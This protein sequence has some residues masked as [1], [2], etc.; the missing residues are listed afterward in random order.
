MAKLSI[1]P[2]RP[3]VRLLPAMIA[4]MLTLVITSCSSGVKEDL[5]ALYN[6]V[7]SEAAVVV[8]GDLAKI[9][10]QCGGKVK[11][12][13]II[14][15][16][17]EGSLS[18]FGKGKLSATTLDEFQKV[19]VNVKAG[20]FAGFVYKGETYLTCM[21]ADAEGLRSVVDAKMPGQWEK[22]GNVECKGDY[23]IVDNDRLWVGDALTGP[24]VLEM[25]QLSEAQS[26]L[27][28]PYSSEMAGSDSA[29]TIW[30]SLDALY[31]TLPF[32]QQAQVRM[33]SSMLFDSPKFLTGTL[34]F[35]KQG[36]ELTLMPMMSDYKAAKCVIDVEKIDVKKVAALGGNA[37]MVLAMGVSQKLV[38]QIQ[39][40]GKSM[41][42]ALPMGMSSM[43]S[44][45]DGT[46]AIA[47]QEEGREFSASPGGYRA[48]VSTN[49][50]Q[51]AAL[52]QILEGLATVKIE[53]NDFHLNEGSYGDGVFDVAEIAK[54]MD[55]AWLGAAVAQKEGQKEE[56]VLML[57]V[58]AEGSLRLKV[59][60]WD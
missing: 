26:F 59:S 19:A 30:M 35:N 31:S 3:A 11:D 23:A 52:G 34:D 55:G 60:V 51:N 41:G 46:I 10:D 27:S 22:T 1:S 38:K 32:S 9:V 44:P 50:E 45:L 20:A 14:T 13:R 18:T 25:M 4:A 54:K 12:E 49:G 17:T 47:S 43:I 2:M 42:G 21:L 33:A 16:G 28:C 8:S 24:K 40:L 53:G 29:A 36:C 7:P 57:L 15:F 6:N 39:D 48:V 56:K 37:N 58:P 5:N